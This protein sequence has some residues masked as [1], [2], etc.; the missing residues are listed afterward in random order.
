MQKRTQNTDIMSVREERGCRKTVIETSDWMCSPEM[1]LK[2]FKSGK[3]TMKNLIIL[4]HMIYVSFLNFLMLS[5]R[6]KSI[7][8]SS[9]CDFLRDTTAQR[10]M[11]S[12]LLLCLA[13]ARNGF[14]LAGA[15]FISKSDIWNRKK[16]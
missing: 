1:M 8:S 2:D 12:I 7:K 15:R 16:V 3:F 4:S 6:H 5:C 11:S 10:A 14:P 13:A 9:D